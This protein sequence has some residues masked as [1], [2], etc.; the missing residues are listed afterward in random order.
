VYT[1]M[2][3]SN[4]LLVPGN[5]TS[6]ESWGTGR[7]GAQSPGVRAGAQSPGVR[8]EPMCRGGRM[9]AAINTT[10]KRYAV[11][12]ALPAL[13]MSK[14]MPPTVLL[15]SL[16]SLNLR[17]TAS[18]I[19]ICRVS[20]S[21]CVSLPPRVSLSLLVCLS[22][23][24]CV[25]LPPR[26][27]LSLSS[28]LP[29]HKMTNTDLSRILKRRSRNKKIR[30]RVLKNPLKNLRIIIMK[31]NPYAK[32]DRRQAILLH[33]PTI[34]AKMLKPK[35]LSKKAPPPCQG[36]KRLVFSNRLWGSETVSNK[37]CRKTIIHLSFD[38]TSLSAVFNS[39]GTFSYN[40]SIY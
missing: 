18:R 40:T 25:S 12:S 34:K 15:Y 24:S 28:S 7:A 19:L 37:I 31:V 16:H 22:P 5:Q 14:G 23:S 20:P 10:Q 21:S 38:F 6:A 17:G 36:I 4:A 13:V 9:F 11:C 30:R 33:D 3:G 27:S 26:V 1:N 39:S 2:T 32:T 29:M 35:K 8:A